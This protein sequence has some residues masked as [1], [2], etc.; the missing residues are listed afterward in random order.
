MIDVNILD[1]DGT[2][3][4]A[5]VHGFSTAKRDNHS[6]LLVLTRPFQD[7]NP[8]FHPFLNDTFGAAMNQN[9]AFSGTPEIIHN[10]GTSAE[11]TGTAIAGTWNFAD[12]GK[13][14]I[15]SASNNDAASFAEESPTTIDMSGFTALTGK[16]DLDV[17]N[18]TNNSIILAFDLA[19]VAVGNSVNLNDSYI[20]TGNFAE[21]SFAIPKADFGL[22]TQLLDGMTI[23]MT[24]LGGTKPTVK[25]DDIQFE[26]TGT[27]AVF[28]A[29]TPPGTR[30]HINRLRFAMADALDAFVTVA[31][32]T[33]NAT[34][35]ALSYNKLLGVSALSNGIVFQQ[36]QNGK[37]NLS[38]A[39]NQLSDFLATG[40]TIADAISDGTNTFIS[41]EL[42]FFEPIVL[43]GG[44]GNFLSLTISDDLSGLLQFT[45]T[46]RGA[47]E[48]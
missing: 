20:D 45:A 41:M 13:V 18:P 47:L 40:F 10:G 46:A 22:A 29:T 30:Y 7:F 36:V 17:Y 4:K 3:L 19:G 21:Q 16:V 28:K 23:T 9:I 24:R 11:W 12:G 44:A 33:E 38:I 43:R 25:F 42:D 8:E 15:T 14:T 26:Q 31:G 2:G 37:V 6:G 1:G 34:L 32:A 5:H 35:P 48:I 39:L 27:P